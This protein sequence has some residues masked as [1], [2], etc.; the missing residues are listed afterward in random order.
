MIQ[1]TASDM[2]KEAIQES[3]YTF[4]YHHLAHEDNGAIFIF[5]HL[6]WGLVHYTYISLVIEKIIS[7]KIDTLADVGCG[8]G[9]IIC[10]LE[11]RNLKTKLFGYDISSRAISFAK[12]FATKSDFSVHDIVTAPLPQT[13]DAVVSCEVIEHIIPE[14]VPTYI[15]NIYRSITD[16]GTLIL[17]T[18]TTNVPVN[19]K[20]YQHFTSEMFDELLQNKFEV[21]EYIYLNKVNWLS[22]TLERL[23]ANRFFISNSHVLN[24]FVLTQY[25]KRFLYGTKE[26]GSRIVVVAKK[27]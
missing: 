25:K 14:Q 20:H 5:E 21:I 18:P 23:L 17:T 1:V 7:M 16:N 11:K 2:N 26:T 22:K 19:A 12:A 9:R 24:R 27:I 13:V 3:Q 4:P 8:E 15:N 10:E 6:F